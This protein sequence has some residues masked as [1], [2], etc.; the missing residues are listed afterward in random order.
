MTVPHLSTPPTANHE[1]SSPPDA[2]LRGRRLVFARLAWF[3]VVGLVLGLFVISIPPYYAYL[4][5]IVPV[6]DLESGQLTERGTQALV[7]LGLSIDSYAVYHILLNGVFAFGFLLV[8]AALFW[9]KADDRMALLTS[10]ALVTFSLGFSGNVYQMRAAS[11]SW[12]VL[13]QL[14]AFVSGTALALIF[15]L[16]PSGRFVPGWARWLMLGWII[17]QAIF[18]FFPSSLDASPALQLFDAVLFISLLASLAVVQVYRYRRVSEAVQRQQTKWVVF[19][20]TIAI[21]G[22]IATILLTSSILP[23]AEPG[24][25]VYFINNT[26]LDLFLLCIPVSIGIAILRSR[27]W[28]IDILINRTLVYGALTL[29]LA[30]VYFGSV[31]V[32]VALLR[33]LTGQEHSDVVIVVSTLAMAALFNPLRR[34]IQSAIDRRFYRRKYDAVKTLAAFSATLRD[35]VDLN[36]L[37][38]E[39]VAVVNDTMQPAHASLWLRQPKLEVRKDKAYR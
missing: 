28:D 20:F 29:S 21:A 32:L 2:H 11:S 36:R 3:A 15:Y 37:T 18:S 34:R 6:M 25:F 24:T 7:S 12:P 16:F 14:V 38:E 13:A 26:A 30:L 17:H 33:T 4:H 19:G 23:T 1:A 10:F 22:F 8:G 5:T 39:L 27:L 35:E 9:R 31:V